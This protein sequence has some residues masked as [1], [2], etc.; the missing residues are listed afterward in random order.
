MKQVIE[1][2]LKEKQKKLWISMIIYGLIGL[3][4]E[5]FDRAFS[6]ALVGYFHLRYISMVGWTSLWMIPVYSIGIFGIAI[7]NDYENYYKKPMW[8]Q[9]ILGGLWVE[10]IE[11]L[12]GILYLKILHLAVWDYSEMPGNI[13]GV[14]CIQNWIL[15]S[16]S[17]P[18]AIWIIDII[19]SL[20]YQENNYYNILDNYK[21]LFT[22]K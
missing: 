6:G 14:I 22:L 8:L 13:M 20:F 16:L 12:F 3:L 17:V 15:F 4:A 5:V 11:F 18:L 9:T 1:I 21:K 19:G 7:L 2:L 10:V